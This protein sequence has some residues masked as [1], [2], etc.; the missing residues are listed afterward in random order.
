MNATRWC[1]REILLSVKDLPMAATTQR[2]I[3]LWYALNW[4]AWYF[5]DGTKEIFISLTVTSRAPQSVSHVQRWPG[6]SISAHVLE[7]QR[8][9]VQEQGK[10]QHSLYNNSYFRNLQPETCM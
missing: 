9:A 7:Q 6:D 1:Y 10:I 3:Y 8:L 5:T 4:M 2:N